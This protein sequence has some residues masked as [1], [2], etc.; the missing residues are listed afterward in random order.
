MLMHEEQIFWG[1]K[2][3][4]NKQKKLYFKYFNKKA[5]LHFWRDSE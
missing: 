3:K 2:Q 5:K 4:T 1:K